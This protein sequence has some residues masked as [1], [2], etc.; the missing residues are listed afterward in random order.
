MQIDKKLS[1]P[2]GEHQLA[3]GCQHLI[4]FLYK[5]QSNLPTTVSGLSNEALHAY[6]EKCYDEMTKKLYFQ[7]VATK[8]WS[9]GTIIGAK[10]QSYM[11]E[12]EQTGWHLDPTVSSYSRRKAFNQQNT[13]ITIVA[14]RWLNLDILVRIAWTS[15]STFGELTL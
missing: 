15:K 8:T 13:I 4:F 7:D 11:I 10:P 6:C 5:I 1:W 9:A 12:A 14:T 2:L 3:P